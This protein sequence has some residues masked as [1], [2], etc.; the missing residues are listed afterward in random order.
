[1]CLR[2]WLVFSKKHSLL[3]HAYLYSVTSYVYDLTA[4][5]DKT[6][7][8]QTVLA[9]VHR[10]FNE[11]TKLRKQVDIKSLLARN[12]LHPDLAPDGKGYYTFPLEIRHYRFTHDPEGKWRDSVRQMM[13]QIHG[14]APQNLTP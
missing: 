1:M 13:Q 8:E 10:V 4:L 12:G 11:K 5:T 14:L 3:Q 9:F 2:F 7:A 6:Q